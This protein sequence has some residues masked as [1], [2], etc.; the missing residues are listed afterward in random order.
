MTFLTAGR[1]R[2]PPA[3]PLVV[4]TAVLPGLL[5]GLLLALIL[6]ALHALPAAAEPPS[7]VVSIKPVHSLVASVMQGVAAPSLLVDG[8]ASPHAYSLKPSQAAALAEADLVVWVGAGLEYFLAAPMQ[9]LVPAGHGLE[10]AA[11]PSIALL[12]VRESGVWDAHEHDAHTDHEQDD[13]ADHAEHDHDAHDDEAGHDHAHGGYDAH[14]WL[15]PGNAI[16]IVAA[17]AERLRAIDPAN[18]V[19]YE[20]NEVATIENL[21]ALDDEIRST[22]APVR[23]AP[24]IVFHDAYQYFEVHYG[25]NAAGSIALDP[26]QKPGAGRIAAIRER[27]AAGGVRCAFAEPGFDSALLETATEGSDVSIGRL[28]PEGI[29]L[30]PGPGLYPALLRDLAA[31]LKTCLATAP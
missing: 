25:L 28:D 4:L 15:D 3:G 26:E 21:R 8:S 2:I 1:R 19:V 9:S 20:A 10:L 17:V 7:V 31:A 5:P 27:L 18:S 16:A 13:H 12:P 22:L 24:F 29:D 11:L 30:E 6:P 23:D 14:I